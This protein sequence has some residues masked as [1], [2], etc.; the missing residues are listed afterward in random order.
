MKPSSLPLP[1]DESKIALNGKRFN[2]IHYLFHLMIDA[3]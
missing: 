1:C 3:D 2:L